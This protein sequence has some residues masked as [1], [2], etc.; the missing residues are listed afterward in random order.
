MM[1]A[2]I[3]RI[4]ENGRYSEGGILKVDRFINHQMDPYLMKHVAVEFMDRFAG[5]RPTKILT[6]EASGIAPAVM[7]GFMMELPVVF[8][9]KKKPSTM[10]DFYAT[11]VHSF[12]KQTDYTLIISKEYLSAEDRVLFVDDFLAFGNTAAGVMNLCRQAGAT[13]VGMGFII[14]KEFQGGRKVLT[15]AGVKHIES[16]AIV[17]SLDG[18]QIKLKGVRTRRVNIYEEA[19][20]CLLCQDAPCTKACKT[21][22]PARAIRAIRFDNHKPALRWVKD[23][24]DDDLERAEQACIHYNWPIRIKEV[25]QNIRQDDVDD[26]HYPDLA[27]DFCGIRCENPFFLASSAVCTSYEMVAQAFDAGWAGVFFKTICMQEIKEVSPRFDAMHNN[28]THDDFYGFRNMEQL[29]ENPVE[30]D[31]DILRRLK[32]DYPTKVVVA[33]I[34]GQTEEEWI[35]LAKMAEE[36]G[37]DAVELNF[38]CPQMKYEGMGSDVGQSPE[39]VKTYTACVKQSVKIP[40]ISKMTPNITHIAEPA[41]ACVE[42]GADAISAINTI[43]SVT[44]DANAEVAGQHSISGYSGRAVR[45]IALRYVLELAQSLGKT[46][47]SGIGGIETWHDALEFIQLGCSNVQVCTAVMQYGYRIIDDL[48]L[49]LQCYMA[50]RGISE[51]R[52]LVGEQLPK[53]LEPDYLDRDTIVFPKIDRDRCIGCGRC[54]VSCQ[55]GGHQAIAFNTDERSPRIEGAK[56][57][58]CHLCR[59]VCPTGAIGIT[60][61]INK[62]S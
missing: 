54:Y 41:T 29:S 60:K 30:T 47:L 25:I 62:K 19:S 2:L 26:C 59:L 57:V 9:K 31:F 13:L 33:S 17:E 61:R 50:K 38:S 4:I 5:D 46:E 55:D 44:M 32:Q 42:A 35:A 10:S 56:C 6:V 3:N 21:G 53:F 43:K 8:A 40:V 37:C 23:C 18:N 27:V 48:I 7:L 15:D 36:A 39:L 1:K 28:A 22:D 34:M 52:Q 11:K 51:L 12:T 58:G 45:P 16:L 49:G 20:R 14:E 24:S